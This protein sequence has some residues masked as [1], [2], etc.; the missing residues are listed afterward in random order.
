MNRQQIDRLASTLKDSHIT[1]T[2]ISWV[3]L[4]G[5][6][7]FKIKKPVRLS[8]LDFSTLALR[9]KYCRIEVQLNR[10]W[11]DIY[12]Q[13]SPVIST[14][15]SLT[16]NG[17]KG[18]IVDYAV[19]MRRV[20]EDLRLDRLLLRKEVTIGQVKDLAGTIA[21]HHARSRVIKRRFSL[22]QTRQL[23]NDLYPLAMKSE[24]LIG[25]GWINVIRDS[26]SWSDKFLEQH[27]GRFTAR[28]RAGLQRD[29]HGDLHSANI[30]LEKTPIIFDCIEFN[31]R[32][33]QID[34]L[35]EAAFLAMDFDAFDSPELAKV[36]ISEYLDRIDTV[37]TPDDRELLVYYK[38]MRAN[39]RA[40]VH[41]INAIQGMNKTDVE[42]HLNEARRYLR[43]MKRYVPR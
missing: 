2:H 25:H 37:I 18:R 39:V 14:A 1:E 21:A 31:S 20:D 33:R 28:I 13:V 5:D 34:I 6:R 38:C 11:S 8:F 22:L 27:S 10:R 35:Y 12:L 19:V 15:G 30:F 3:I 16:V 42:F 7:A 24:K 4:S 32:Y 26:V 23:F 36:F 43:L 17:D 40:K 29:V 41:L 9:K